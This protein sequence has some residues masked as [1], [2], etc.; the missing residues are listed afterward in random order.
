MPGQAG[1]LRE[2]RQAELQPLVQMLEPMPELLEREQ[3]LLAQ[4]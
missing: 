2:A 4:V 3:K 1:G